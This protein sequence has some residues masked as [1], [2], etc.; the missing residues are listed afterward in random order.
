MSALRSVLADFGHWQAGSAGGQLSSD[1][2]LYQTVVS[3]CGE[4]CFDLAREMI[5]V[6]YSSFNFDTISGPV[7]AW[8]FGV[9]C[10]SQ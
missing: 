4:L 9:L 10:K 7:P 5:E 3:E 2:A 6:I 1:R 8:W